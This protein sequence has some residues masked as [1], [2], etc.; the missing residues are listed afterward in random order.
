MSTILASTIISNAS[1]ILQDITN[2][3]WPLTELLE[4]LNEGQLEIARVKPNAYVMTQPVQLVPGVT[5]SIPATGISLID[6]TRNLGTNGATPGRAIRKIERRILD[7]QLPYWAS[8]TPVAE[9]LHFAY[10][11]LDI[12]TFYVYPPQPAVGPNFVEMQYAAA[13]VQLTES[14]QVITLDDVYAAVLTDYLLYR[15]YAKDIDYAQN[16]ASAAFYK[17]AFEDALMQKTAGEMAT[18]TTKGQSAVQ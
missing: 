15:A 4:W 7:G 16:A 8:S 3:R 5:Q 18:A 9:V 13:P 10:T 1:I 14:T 11:P 17:K 2:V 6:I 12:R